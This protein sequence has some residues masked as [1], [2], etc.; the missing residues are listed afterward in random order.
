MKNILFLLLFVPLL[1]N[2][3]DTCVHTPSEF[4]PIRGTISELLKDDYAIHLNIPITLQ[5]LQGY[6]ESC[7]QDTCWV[8]YDQWF[9][10]KISC[11]LGDGDYEIVK[12]EYK[13]ELQKTLFLVRRSLTLEGF[14]KYLEEQNY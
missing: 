9:Q 14:I 6:Q 5:S 10:N 11:K 8:T 7:Y 1:C 12:D 4:V 13:P 3:Q 2:G